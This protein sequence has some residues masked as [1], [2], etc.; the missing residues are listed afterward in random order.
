MNM[1]EV[2][3]RPLTT[4][5]TYGLRAVNAYAFEVHGRATKHEVKQAVEKI[6]DVSVVSVNVIN[7]PAKRRRAGHRWIVRQQP[8]RKAVVRLAP[9]QTIRALD[10]V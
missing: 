6:F 5:K 7:L 2:I 10:T 8:R 9:G 1:Y 3:R 4:E